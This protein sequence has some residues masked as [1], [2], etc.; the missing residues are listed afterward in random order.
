MAG[1]AESGSNP[2]VELLY[3]INGL[4]KDA[5]H[6]FDRVM[7]YVGEYGLLFA[8]I[9]AVVWC[10]WSVRR[11]GAEDAASSVAAL[12]WAPLAAGVAVLVNV[13][14]RGFVE[15]P[16]PFNQHQGLEVLVSGKTDYSFVSDHA[17]IAMALGVGLFVANRKFG[18]VGIGLAL[19]EGFCRVYMGVHYPTDVV[20][21]FALGTAVALLLSPLAMALLTPLMSAIE[22]SPRG[23]WLIRS[24]GRSRDGGGEALIP[25]ARKESAGAEERDLAA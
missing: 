19:L 24:R 5:P 7:G 15:R 12:V 21:G 3:D 16:R 13:P 20:G 8:L 1:L 22:R 18:L 10:W 6:W 25:G 11:R 23:G 2:D 17:T 9:L 14:I 4:A